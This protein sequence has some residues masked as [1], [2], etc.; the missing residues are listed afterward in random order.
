[1]A[2]QFTPEIMTELEKRYRSEVEIIL[3]AR[4]QHIW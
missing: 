4:D 1:M 2:E 3:E